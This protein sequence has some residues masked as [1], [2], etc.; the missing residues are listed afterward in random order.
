[1]EDIEVIGKRVNL[2]IKNIK[3]IKIMSTL[4]ENE[5]KELNE[6]KKLDYVINK[7]IISYYNSDEIKTLLDL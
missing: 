3:R 1:M 4:L 6:K 5:V 2:D 7:A